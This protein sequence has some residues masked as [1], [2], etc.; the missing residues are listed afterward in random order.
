MP[1]YEYACHDC[2]R[3]FELLVRGSD[4]P[5]CPACDSPRLDKLLSVPAAHSQSGG[6]LPMCLP[7]P[8]GGCGL[9]Q[10]GQGGC[11]ME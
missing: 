11:M 1:L 10:C 8:A 6:E 3:E 5:R 9:T 7:R 4:E 2:R